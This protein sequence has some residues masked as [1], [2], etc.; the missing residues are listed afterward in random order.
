MLPDGVGIAAA[1]L[2]LSALVYLDVRGAIEAK[3]PA[4]L[5]FQGVSLATDNRAQ[6]I[7]QVCGP[8][9]N[10][11]DA[12]GYRYSWCGGL[13]G[14]LCWQDAPAARPRTR[15][16]SRSIVLQMIIIFNNN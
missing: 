10:L 7:L 2:S 1:T 6:V 8:F 11:Q 16:V 14:G 9:Y 5:E 15:Y 12:N 13:L 4:P 3:H